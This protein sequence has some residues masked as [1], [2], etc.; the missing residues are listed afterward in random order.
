MVKERVIGEND[1]R[2]SEKS[3]WE[4]VIRE[5]VCMRQSQ[6]TL[7]LCERGVCV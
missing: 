6:V 1:K 7:C 5:R 4:R 2:E 3:L